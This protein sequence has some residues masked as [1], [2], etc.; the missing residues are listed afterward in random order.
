MQELN[1]FRSYPHNHSDILNIIT[2]NIVIGERLAAAVTAMQT[3]W[4][5]VDV[6]DI[7]IQNF[8]SNLL[9]SGIDS[10]LHKEG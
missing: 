8:L 5:Y 9:F 6:K 3:A 4:L 7:S 2:Q 10:E 1:Y